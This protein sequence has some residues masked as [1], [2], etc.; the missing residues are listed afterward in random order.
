MNRRP[1]PLL[2]LLA[3]FTV[4]VGFSSTAAA[5]APQYLGPTGIVAA[6][7]GQSLVAVHY[8]GRQV[9][10]LDLE[11]RVQRSIEMPAPPTGAAFS[12]DGSRLY[13]T[14]EAP[15]STIAVVE[16]ASGEIVGELS[17]GHTA[18]APVVHPDGDTLYVSNRFNNEVA[19]I[20]LDDGEIV[21][22]AEVIREPVAAAI[23][24][25]GATLVVG[26]H[27]PLD[28]S[29]SFDVA[30]EVAL[31]DTADGSLEHVRLPNGTTALRGVAIDPEGRYAYATHILAR[32]QLPT[33]QLERGWMN[34]NALSIIDLE[35]REHLNTVLLDD[36]DLGAANPWGVAVSPDGEFVVV[37]HAGTHEVS[38]IDREGLIEKLLAMPT[39]RPEDDDYLH[40]PSASVTAADVPNDLAFL[41]D[42]RRRVPLPG[43]GARGLA[44]VGQRAYVAQY[45]TDSMAV[46]DL[47]A[48]P[49]V[50]AAAVALGPEVE[51]TIE[52]L[53]E[54]HFNDAALCFQQWQSCATCHPDIRVDGLN[55]DL[56][57]D[58]IGNPKNT[59]S[60]LLSHQ[61]P[62]SMS[63]GV[64]ATAED[65]VRAGLIHIQFA[66][67]PEADAV[68]MD[69]FL[70]ALEPVPSPYLVDGELSESARRG[71]EVFFDEKVGCAYCHPAPLYADSRLHDVGTQ[72]PYDDSP[73]YV[74]PTL[75]EVWRTAPYLHDGRYL[76]IRELMVEGRHGET[77]GDLDSLTEQQMDDLIEFVLSL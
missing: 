76:T 69:E 14:C 18:M 33:T 1:G 52:R 31:I 42:L 51:L 49:R 57:N 34:T 40:R 64:R 47:T 56:L 32:Y 77:H 45:F 29:N 48:P 3:I 7:D 4:V 16:V 70:K 55:W 43:N 65:A 30:A 11:G 5:E 58:G 39:E 23:T 37:A 17:A 24:P 10:M 67:R 72:T 22:R 9:A 71:K 75:V 46:V 27:L 15:R 63:L 59:K 20:R 38:V 28:R 50:A 21:W 54:R 68:A 61:T 19:A 2:S 44:V 26:N 41:L 12:P 53:G 62:P 35:A 74:T 36:V 6:P 73:E 13:V 25:D 60:M 8:D 66:V